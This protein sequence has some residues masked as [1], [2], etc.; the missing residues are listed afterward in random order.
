MGTRINYF[1]KFFYHINRPKKDL[2]VWAFLELLVK[3]TSLVGPFIYIQLIDFIMVNSQLYILK[4]IIIS[5]VFIYI[6]TSILKLLSLN[7]HNKFFLKAEATLQ[8]T[9]LNKYLEIPVKKVIEYDLGNLKK[10]ISED[11][12]AVLTILEKNIVQYTLSILVIIVLSIVLFFISPILAIISYLFIPI[13][14]WITQKIGHC[15]ENLTHEMRIVQGNYEN[16]LYNILGNWE[17]IKFNSLFPKI[18]FKTENYWIKI[19]KLIMKQ[20][21]FS[22]ANRAFISFK[23]YV[24]LEM[25]LYFIGGS[26]IFSNKLTIVNLI[27]FMSYLSIFLQ[28]VTEISDNIYDYHR[29]LPQAQNVFQMLSLNVPQGTKIDTFSSIKVDNATVSSVASRRNIFENIS[30]EIAKG[31]H[32]VIAGHNG[33]GK[34]TFL[35]AI[36]GIQPLQS[37]KILINN[38][39]INEINEK[40]LFRQIGYLPQNP[41]FISG[42]IR[43]NLLIS[44]PELEEEEILSVCQKVNLLDFILSLPEQLDTEIGDNGIRLSG[45]Q[46]Q[47]LAIAR[48]L[49]I[50][51]EVLILDEITASMDEEN[52]QLIQTFLQTN[53]YEKTIIAISHKWEEINTF[54]RIIVFNAGKIVLDD[55]PND[56]N[57]DKIYHQ[58]S[59]ALDSFMYK[60]RAQE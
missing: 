16:E 6:V 23:D 59:P 52:S 18:I 60:N 34:T 20:Q 32:I 2:Y 45:G 37:G 4:Y 28:S 57:K 42:T 19:S 40:T 25:G 50:Q 12:V 11:V 47:R 29:N 14:F 38:I 22:F 27:A 10:I 7:F 26:M 13:S 30:L 51:P 8:N 58:L 5:M 9:L 54:P 15:I 48:L 33:S 43:D 1:K 46:K 36:M 39:P 49:L 55:T 35:K 53:F 56:I 31:E 17:I 44:N 21:K 41:H 3:I 24:V